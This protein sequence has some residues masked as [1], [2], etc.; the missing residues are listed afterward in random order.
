MIIMNIGHVCFE[1]KKMAADIVFNNEKV[2]SGDKQVNRGFTSRYGVG[3]LDLIGKNRSLVWATAP[4]E[5]FAWLKTAK[6]YLY[7]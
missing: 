2:T 5:G 7:G 6:Y 3:Q 1:K 4:Y